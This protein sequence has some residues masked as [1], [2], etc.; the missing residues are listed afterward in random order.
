MIYW[1]S[2]IFYLVFTCICWY[3]LYAP[4][5]FTRSHWI[6]RPTSVDVHCC[7]WFLSMLISF[8]E[9]LQMFN[10]SSILT[11]FW[12]QMFLNFKMT[13]GHR[14]ANHQHDLCPETLTSTKQVTNHSIQNPFDLCFV[15]M[16][17]QNNF[18]YLCGHWTSRARNNMPKY[19]ECTRNLASWNSSPEPLGS[20]E[21]Q[22]RIQAEPVRAWESG[23]REFITSNKLLQINLQLFLSS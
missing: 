8:V 3:V 7:S 22:K 13:P 19:R 20:T 9:L 15:Y 17:K 21:Y 18:V 5:W 11:T 10:Y 4:R 12:T 14:T 16:P 23:L 6:Y 2:L 1:P